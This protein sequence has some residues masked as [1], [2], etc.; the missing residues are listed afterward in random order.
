MTTTVVLIQQPYLYYSGVRAIERVLGG[1]L[2]GALAALLGLMFHSQLSLLLMMFPLA[3]ACMSFRAVNYSLFVLFLTPLFV[4]I[5]DL[6]HPGVPEPA[7][8]GIRAMNTVIGGAI[9]LAGSLLLW[10]GSEGD[11]LKL[12]LADAIERNGKLASIALSTPGEDVR[13]IRAARRAAGLASNKADEARR[14]A[15]LEIWWRRSELKAADE[16][17]AALRRLAGTAVALWLDGQSEAGRESDQA[18]G[19]WGAQA[20]ASAAQALREG[21]PLPPEPPAPEPGR[22]APIIGEVETLY[23]AARALAG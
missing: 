16:V 9:A 22:A 21:R 10:P 1:V 18:M 2:G 6:T 17:L 23:R 12:A 5:L 19:D 3:M 20:T 11:R 4:L 7:I 8:A 14:R 13:P 15:G